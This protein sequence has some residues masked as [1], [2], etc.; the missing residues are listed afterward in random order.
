MQR[1]SA[2]EHRGRRRRWSRP[3]DYANLDTRLRKRAT[4][5]L[6]CSLSDHRAARHG[7]DAADPQAAALIACRRPG[8][9]VASASRLPPTSIA[10][11]LAID[12]SD[13]SRTVGFVI[14]RATATGRRARS[15]LGA[16]APRMHQSPEL[17]VLRTRSDPYRRVRRAIASSPEPLVPDTAK[18]PPERALWHPPGSLRSWPDRHS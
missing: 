17:T 9:S 14:G 13:D 1:G 18:A 5:V 11:R 8:P 4:Y 10:F 12:A 7:G 3:G 2:A 15:I 6:W 16:M